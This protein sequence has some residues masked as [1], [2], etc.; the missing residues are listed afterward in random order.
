[1]CFILQTGD[2]GAGKT[3]FSRGIVR[4][5]FNDFN[6]KVTS[7]SY[8]LDNCYRY[9]EKQNIHHMDLYRMPPN[10]DLS[11]LGIPEVF[12]DSLCLVEWPQRM[13]SQFHPSSYL[14]VAIVIG[15]D[16][17]RFVDVQFVGDRWSIPQHLDRFCDIWKFNLDMFT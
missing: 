13:S 17:K 9:G 3:T 4:A 16:E 15:E 7:P 5:K 6:M 8:L 11:I 10:S 1:L 14:D 12:L 2:L